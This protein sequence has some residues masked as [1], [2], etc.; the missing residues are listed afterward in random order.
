MGEMPGASTANRS[1]VCKSSFD[2][3]TM[4]HRPATA[5]GLPLPPQ[6]CPKTQSYPASQ[7]DQQVRRFAESVIA[8]P[9]P[10]IRSQRCHHLFHASTFGLPRDFPDSSLEPVHC[11]RRYLPPNIRTVRNTEPKK[12][13]LLRPRHRTLLVVHLELEPSCNEPLNTF[14]HPLPRPFASD[15]Y[16]TVV[17]LTN[18]SMTPALQLP[19]EF[20]EHEVAEQRRKGASL[21][22][23]FH[24]GTFQPVLH[25]SGV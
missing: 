14:H 17:R 19:V 16:V 5:W 8:S 25:H 4:Q 12:L 3:Q 18:E 15:V 11:F 1:V 7:L 23:S 22:S 10:H 13:P 21:R 24:T 2:A 9:S 6:R 20:V